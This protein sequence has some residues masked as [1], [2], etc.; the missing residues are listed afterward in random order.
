M[1]SDGHGAAGW[2]TITGALTGTRKVQMLATRSNQ[3]SPHQHSSVNYFAYGSNLWQPRLERRVG[4]LA[5]PRV[6]QLFNHQLCWHKRSSDGSGKC[7]AIRNDGSVVLGALYTLE[8]AQIA[9]LDEIEGVGKGYRR[10][11]S[12]S[13]ICGGKSIQIVTYIAEL[14]YVDSSLQPYAWYHAFVLAGALELDFPTDY[15]A[16]LR[17][18]STKADPDLPRSAREAKILNLRAMG[19]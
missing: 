17:R 6:A 14:D 15:V 8:A 2:Q 16:R 5:R 19:G 11:E 13:V 4:A 18:Q 1:R 7:D 10:D 3:R 9:Q 12:L